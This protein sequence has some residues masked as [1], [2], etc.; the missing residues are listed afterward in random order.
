[1]IKSINQ[2]CFKG[3]TPLEQ[4]MAI[5]SDAGFGA[6]ELNLYEPGGIGL[7]LDTTAAEAEKIGKLA[8][9]HG[10]QLRS[11]STGL[12]WQYPLSSADA[13]VREQGRRVVT[14]QLELAELLGMD[15]VL[16]VPGSVN[17]D[18]SYDQCYE[19]SHKEVQLLSKEAEKRKTRIGI[20]N[21]WNK[22][23]LSPLEMAR[24]VDDIGSPYV[25]A[26]FDVGNVLLYGYPEQ[27]I[28]ILG[29]R[30]FKIH[31]KDFLTGVGNGNGFVSLLAGDV[32]WKAVR[33]ALQ[34][35]N[36]TDTVT[37]ELGIYA[38]NPHQL[39]YDT[40]RHLDIIFGGDAK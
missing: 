32:N 20:E 4:V 18:T 2:W 1:M 22:F 31:V 28:R 26:Y 17:P 6:V 40:S 11:L 38:A 27:W 10:L 14:K 19:R 15:T 7:T 39:V 16:V 9:D 37:A 12:L 34:E 21:V 36:Y 33:E 29:D 5:S 25:G 30:I 13:S 35:I 3:D 8:R 24:Y 23:L